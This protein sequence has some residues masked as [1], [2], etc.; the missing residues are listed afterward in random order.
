MTRIIKGIPV[1]SKPTGRPRK[2][3]LPL[4]KM[5]IGD[6]VKI[7]VDQDKHKEAKLI[8][9]FVGRYVKKNPNRQYTVRTLDDGV[10]IW[11]VA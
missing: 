10:G 8:R 7:T 3:D 4:D 6:H 11:R 1:P 2:Y 5:S 9:N